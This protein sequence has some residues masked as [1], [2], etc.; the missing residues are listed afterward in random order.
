HSDPGEARAQ[1]RLEQLAT[2]LRTPRNGIDVLG[3]RLLL[4]RPDVRGVERAGSAV[5]DEVPAITHAPAGHVATVDRLDEGRD[6]IYARDAGSRVSLMS[7]TA[8]AES[9]LGTL[10]AL[11]NTTVARAVRA[12][13]SSPAVGRRASIHSWRAGQL[14]SGHQQ[15][16]STASRT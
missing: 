2:S 3:G 6:N 16:R 10:V 13:Q 8:L 1:L 7:S 4:Y 14:S 5:T 11:P 9:T 12:D 15:K